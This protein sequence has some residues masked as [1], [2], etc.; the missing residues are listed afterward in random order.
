MRKGTYD[1]EDGNFA[2]AGS[3]NF[4]TRDRLEA[5]E[6]EAR[7]G[8]FNT[9]HGVVMMPFG[10]DESEAGGYLMLSGHY[11]DGPTISPQKYERFNGFAKLTAPVGDAAEMVAY[12]VGIRLAAGIASGQ[13]P[14]QGG[15]K[16]AASAASGPSTRHR[17]RASPAATSVSLS[18]RSWRVAPGSVGRS[19][20][21]AVK[22]RLRSVLELHL[23]PQRSACM[24]TGSIRPTTA[25]SQGLNASYVRARATR[26][27]S[28]GA[29]P[30]AQVGRSD[31]AAVG[32][33]TVAR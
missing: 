2:T 17:G 25:G 19:K 21:Y 26:R 7:A 10:G 33:G 5:Q 30:S 8:T 14:E 18:L 16:A 13:V 22:L 15:R 12:R 24:G 9:A 4:R 31:W 6:V 20:A 29:P 27:R 28:E 3:V 23:L 1:A 11:T 32:A